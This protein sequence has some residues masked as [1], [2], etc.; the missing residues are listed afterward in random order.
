MIPV[1]LVLAAAMGACGV[2][3][4]AVAAHGGSAAVNPSGLDGA[5]FLLLLHATAILGAAALAGQR[6]LR[7]VPALAAM[8][9]FAAGAALFAGDI[10]MRAFA[11]ARLFPM[12]A[13]TGGML[14]LAGWLILAVAAAVVAGEPARR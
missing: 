7:R 14:L 3:L 13:P 2:G 6:L 10:A 8:I 12:A 9:A 11:G 5:A 1:L 4:A